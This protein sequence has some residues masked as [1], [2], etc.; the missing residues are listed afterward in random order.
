MRHR[1]AAV[2]SA[3]LALG[4]VSGCTA[5][6]GDSVATRRQSIQTM[7][8]ATLVKLDQLNPSARA[9]LDRAEGYAVF[10][11]VGVNVVLVAFGNGYGVVR[12]N[13]SG[14][15]TYMKMA[16][17]GVGPGLGAKDF[18]VVFVFKTRRALDEFVT[19]GWDAGASADAAAKSATRG[20]AA[21]GARSIDSD[22]VI[23]Q[24]TEAGLAAQAT[25]GGT[26]YWRDDELG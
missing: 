6:A 11:T 23:Y 10:S 24:I 25:I 2:L 9:S 15:D 14:Q 1:L 17:G 22:I 19:F 26:R 20:G 4:I 16:S 8:E 13:R 5:P 3:V 21:G 7:R 12:D 18:R